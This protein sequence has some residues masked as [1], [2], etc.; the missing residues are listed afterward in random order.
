MN[1]IGIQIT[2]QN[3]R[4]RTNVRGKT[5]ANVMPSPGSKLSLSSPGHNKSPS[6]LGKC[7]QTE[8]QPEGKELMSKA[9]LAMNHA[10]IRATGS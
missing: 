5:V 10:V 7:L 8:A 6:A 1:A 3:H 9:M 4:L 2:I